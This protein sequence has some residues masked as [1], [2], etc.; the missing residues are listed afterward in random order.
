MENKIKILIASLIISTFLILLGI[1][2]N[3]IRI[4]GNSF[5]I[6]IVLIIVPQSIFYYLEFRAAKE[7]EEKFPDFLRDVVE[8]IRAG[9]PLYQAIYFCSKNEYG[10]ALTKEV[11]RMANKISWGIKLEKV[12]DEF[13]KRAYISKKIPIAVQMIKEA[14]IS[15]GDVV[16]IMEYLSESLVEIENAEKE[17]ASILNQYVFL[18]YTL[19]IIFL[20]IVVALHRFLIPLFSTVGGGTLLEAGRMENPCIN[21][22]YTDIL[23]NFANG[24][25]PGF[26]CSS[27]YLF[28]SIL[29]INFENTSS[30]YLT[31]FF[32]MII[33][34]STFSGLVAGEVSHGSLRAGIRH[35]L[36]LLFINSGIFILLVG[37]K[38]LV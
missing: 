17:R 29:S 12:L 10:K 8:N 2:M 32:L 21:Y 27:L 25:I 20:I 35:A 13:S 26:V 6:S 31:L 9:V 15:G 36:T 28:S 37:L 22:D 19:S 5:I 18:M 14:Y 3:D 16:N 4:L 7:M 11:R 1:I 33:V 24:N 30:Y 34:Q 23:G 38:I